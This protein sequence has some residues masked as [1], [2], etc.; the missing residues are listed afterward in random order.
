[1]CVFEKEKDGKDYEYEYKAS[2]YLHLQIFI[3]N[4]YQK[5][6]A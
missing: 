6:M 4:I 1:M 5:I 3:A 2:E